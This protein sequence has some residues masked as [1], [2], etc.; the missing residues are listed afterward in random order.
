MSQNG[1][2]LKPPEHS[3][4][5]A[6]FLKS[7]I[8]FRFGVVKAMIRGSRHSLFNHFM[9]ALLKKYHVT[10]KISIAYHLQTSGKIEVSCHP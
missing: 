3:K 6:D 8:F 5:V 10:H 1:W 7:N 9:E 4:V 2:N